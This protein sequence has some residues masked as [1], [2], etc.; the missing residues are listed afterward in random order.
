MD[1]RV[2][3]MASS[4]KREGKKKDWANMREM[5]TASERS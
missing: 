3:E 2:F 5:G 4:D 1:H